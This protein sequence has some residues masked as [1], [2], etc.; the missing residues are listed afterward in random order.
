VVGGSYTAGGNQHAF[1]TGPDGEGMT[2]LNSLVDLPQGTILV[3]QWI[4]ITGVK[5]LLLLFLL[6]F[7]NL[8]PMP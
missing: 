1:I 8:N 4:S 7:P 2:D 3:R 5:S 6:L